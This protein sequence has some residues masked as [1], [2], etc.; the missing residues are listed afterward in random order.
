[1]VQLKP[2]DL[3][4]TE[5]F[6]EPDIVEPTS[7]QLLDAR[8]YVTLG[9]TVDQKTDKTIRPSLTSMESCT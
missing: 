5:V 6:D 7:A 9:R 4:V 1:M 3:L 8:Y 2:L